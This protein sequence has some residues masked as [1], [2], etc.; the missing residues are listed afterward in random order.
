M[1][2]SPAPLHHFAPL[3]YEGA[4]NV[5]SL[6]GWFLTPGFSPPSI[7]TLQDGPVTR[8]TSYLT[9]TMQLIYHHFSFL[10]TVKKKR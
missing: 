9:S 1:P 4:K 5:A 3:I 10:T 8:S 6:F 2:N 7:S